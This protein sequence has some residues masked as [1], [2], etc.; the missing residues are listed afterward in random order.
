[1]TPLEFKAWFEGYTENIKGAPTQ[2][3]WARIQERVGQID[4]TPLKQEVI[5]RY[6]PWYVCNTQIP[7]PTTYFT[8][9]CGTLSAGSGKSNISNNTAYATLANIGRQEALNG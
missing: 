2:K 7:A 3:Q 6:W 4:G 5:H 9:T 8:T 1:M